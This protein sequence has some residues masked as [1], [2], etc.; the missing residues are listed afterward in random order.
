MKVAWDHGCNRTLQPRL[1]SKNNPEEGNN[2]TKNRKLK[3]KIK[4]EKQ[5]TQ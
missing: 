2:K 5:A 4:K 1:K 3:T